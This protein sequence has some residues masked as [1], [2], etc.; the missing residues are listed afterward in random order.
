MTAK[1]EKVNYIDCYGLKLQFCCENE[2][3]VRKKKKKKQEQQEGWDLDVSDFA[4][5]WMLFGSKCSLKGYA[6]PQQQI[7]RGKCCWKV[8]IEYL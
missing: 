5:G 2:G 3:N 6:S 8:L 1:T 7:R 4:G